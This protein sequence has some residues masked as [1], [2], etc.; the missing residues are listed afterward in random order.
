MQQEV[1]LSASSSKDVSSTLIKRSLFLTKGHDK[2]KLEPDSSCSWFFSKRFGKILYGRES[3]ALFKFQA[4]VKIESSQRE[5][6]I[7]VSP[8]QMT[9]SSRPFEGLVLAQ[10]IRIHSGE[11]SAYSRAIRLTN[12]SERQM[13]LRL[14]TL[15]DPT[16]LNFRKEKEP[17]GEIGVNAFNRG[18]HIVM[19]D[20]GDS[21]G[22][23]V[24]GSQ[25]SPSVIY[26]TREKHR[27]ND[28][29]AAGELPEQT[30]GISGAI[31][32]LTQ[33]DMDL[34]PSA[35]LEIRMS[36]LYNP[37]RLEEALMEFNGL[38]EIVGDRTAHDTEPSFACSSSSLGFCF[39]WAKAR[40]DS[41]EQETNLLELLFSASALRT[42]RPSYLK[43][44]LER[45][46][47]LQRKD[48]FLPHSLDPMKA[49]V[50][51]TCQFLIAVCE[52]VL[53][54]GDRKLSR[55]MQA[56]LRRAADALV[57]ASKGGLISCD[58]SLPQGWR[59]RLRSGYPSAIITEVNLAASRALKEYASF[60]CS[61]GK[62]IDSA[63]YREVSEMIL[64]SVNERLKDQENGII[65]LNIDPHGRQH[66]EITVDSSVAIS[67]NSSDHNLA[68]SVVHRLLDKDF[69]TGYGPR[70]VPS[71]NPLYFSSAYGEGQLGGYSTR[72]ALTHALLAYQSGYAG[73]GS[74]QL[75]K[76]AKLVHTD[77]ERMGGVPGEF[78][79][80]LDPD[81]KVITSQ[82]SDPV[83]AS[84]LVDAVLYG[85]L[86]LS[87][88]PTRIELRPAEN[89]RLR[90]LSAQN[91][92]ADSYGSFFLGREGDR[93]YSAS[94]F[95]RCE[96]KNTL[97]LAKC[98]KVPA[99]A[100]LEC[101]HFF[102]PRQLLC[103]GNTSGSE[104]STSVSIPL[105]DNLLSKSL[106]AGVEEL[107]PETG[108][109][110]LTEKIRSSEKL[111]LKLTVRPNSWKM[112]RIS[113]IT[114]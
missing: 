88:N 113:Q 60:A 64:S 84:R 110:S 44:L 33:H 7:R 95:Q 32:I 57:N 68:S 26:M 109:W 53:I 100:A 25:P 16:S 59:R 19:D 61:L 56:V 96:S 107:D 69:E 35:S 67:Y 76:V 28:L 103:A 83:A 93:V 34:A 99:N 94:T 3:L 22:V 17:P 15:H 12:R 49:G 81:R 91:F 51:E 8:G 47:S 20:V 43:T 23:R 75:E 41:I 102:G 10:T 89:S 37:S 79:Y 54:Q 77:C 39:A 104:T 13:R 78:P 111:S 14:I 42:L 112:L 65:M 45:I 92:Y 73:I 4:G 114:T 87:L 106:F 86:G 48:G 97:K 18:A 36:S 98:E 82:G 101:L 55:V 1:S 105:K 74:M 21:T 27:V 40:L 38:S 62:G 108:A 90:L 58:P 70:T 80:W 5:N 31:A 24:F 63:K 6:M 29:I 9:F 2:L 85:E 30:A 72:A 71:S 50:L 46:K 11:S 66:K 52:C